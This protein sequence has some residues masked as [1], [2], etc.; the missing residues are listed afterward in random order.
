MGDRKPAV[1]LQHGLF[2]S[3]DWWIM[4][5]ADSPAFQLAAEGY[6]VW[7]GNNR[8]NVYSRKHLT[9]DPVNDKKFFWDFSHYDL[10]KYDV[11]AQVDYIMDHTGG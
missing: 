4:N 8:G 3:S 2:E 5:K 1:L 9:L 11:K 10:G 7:L 6:D